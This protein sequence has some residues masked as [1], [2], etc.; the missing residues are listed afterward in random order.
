MLYQTTVDSSSFLTKIESLHQESN[1]I[2]NNYLPTEVTDLKE[3]DL[4]DNVNGDPSWWIWVTEEMVPDNLEEACGIDNENY[5]IISDEN[6]GDGIVEFIA[7]C[8][9]ENPRTKVL[10]PE[11]LQRN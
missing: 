5:V 2:P 10:T 6:V 8:I 7:K 9:H 4:S 3:V 11:Q 1:A